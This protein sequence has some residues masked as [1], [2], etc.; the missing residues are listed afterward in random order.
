MALISSWTLL[1]FLPSSYYIVCPRILKRKKKFG[2][3]LLISYLAYLPRSSI[4]QQSLQCEHS[5]NIRLFLSFLGTQAKVIREPTDIKIVFPEPQ[6]Q[7]QT[8]S[9]SQGPSRPR[10]SE[11]PPRYAPAPAREATS[12]TYPQPAPAPVSPPRYAPKQDDDAPRRQQY[13]SAPPPPAPQ[14]QYEQPRKPSRKYSGEDERPAAGE[15]P[16]VYRVRTP[17]SEQYV[18]FGGN[19]ARGQQQPQDED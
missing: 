17:T 16:G 5:L 12:I 4:S 15:R 13:Y 7:E 2:L 19:R 18:N 3:I 11:E 14:Q 1:L 8:N 6:S 9:Y 10:Y